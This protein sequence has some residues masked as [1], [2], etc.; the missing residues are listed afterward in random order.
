MSVPN[1]GVDPRKERFEQEIQEMQARMVGIIDSA[2]D[3]IVSIDAEQKIILFNN[4]A[5]LMFGYTNEQAIGQPLSLLLPERF[6]DIHRKHIQNFAGTG[7]TRRRMGRLGMIFGRRADGE[8][9]PIEASISQVATEKGNI[10]T[11]IL[12]DETERVQ[13]EEEINRREQS[14]LQA[15]AENARLLAQSESQLRFVSSLR[16]IDLA[17][18]SASDLRVVLNILLDQVVTQLKADAAVVF[19]VH[20]VTQDLD[21]VAGRGLFTNLLKTVDQ[22]GSCAETTALER[23]VVLNEQVDTANL[24]QSMLEFISAE[25]IAACFSAPLIVKGELE[26]VLE[27]FQRAPYAPDDEWTGK[28]EALA[29]QAAIAIGGARLFD[30]LQRSNQQLIQAY[31]ST[32]EGW[33]RALDLRDHE[34]E[35]HTR[36]VTDMTMRVARATGQFSDDELLNI[37]R[38]ALLHDIGKM[39]VPDQILRK[40]DKLTDEE[41]EIMKKHPEHAYRLLEPI[42]FLRR[43]LDIPRYHH[44][45]WDGSGYPYG[46]K[47]DVIPLPARLF[48]VVD[49]WDALRHERPYRPGWEED[50]VLAYLQERSGAHFDPYAVT[51]FFQALETNP[52]KG[53]SRPA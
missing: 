2:M 16:T 33:S 36:R 43:S 11:V 14:L 28:F 41:W 37:R 38:G 27:V 42:T 40:Q 1:Q 51:M 30:R 3:A 50:T 45:R 46:L 7:Q 31:D 47:G 52:P 19:L 17:I 26:G 21:F 25:Q 48:S 13:A 23:A 34:T 5:E 9:F 39:G 35:G 24:A 8:E 29:G 15:A 44:E 4:A 10:F 18:S 49:V 22:R 32:I 53:D 20:P 6:H 12:R